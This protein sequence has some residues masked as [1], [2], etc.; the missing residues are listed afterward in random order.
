MYMLELAFHYGTVSKYLYGNDEEAANY[1]YDKVKTALDQF[2][3]FKNDNV[4]TVEIN[5]GAGGGK[6]TIRLEHLMS[7]S[8]SDYSKASDVQR[9]WAKYNGE[10][11]GVYDCAKQ[12]S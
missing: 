1:D 9:D 7:V 8:L 4:H 2:R 11:Q 3:Q 12:S 5:K 6:A 10:L